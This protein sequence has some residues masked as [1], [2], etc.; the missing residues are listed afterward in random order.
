MSALHDIV[1]I[2]GGPAGLQ[3]GYYLQKTSLKYL[4][5]EKGNDVGEFFQHF[6][7]G[8]DL[9][10]YNKVHTV[11]NDPE[12]ALK[13]DWNSLL[14]EEHS[15]LMRDFSRKLFPTRQ[16]LQEYFT[17]F[18]K[19]HSI[20]TKAGS[21]VVGVKRV[22]LEDL[23]EGTK[24][25][26]E[27]TLADGTQC[28]AA[29]VV[30][31]TGLSKPNIP[32]I[33]GIGHAEGYENLKWDAQEFANQR[34]L[35]L[36]KGNS[37]FELSTLLLDTAAV[38]FMVSPSP[39]K[40]AWKTHH[41]GHVRTNHNSMLDMYQLKTL[42]SLLDAEVQSIRK[43]CDGEGKAIYKVRVAYAHAGGE[44]EELAF[45]R[46][47]RA[48][49]FSCDLSFFDAAIRPNLEPKLGGGNRFP[50]LTPAFE[51]V[52]SPGVFFAGSLTQALDFQTSS[53]P[54][55]HGFRY[56][57]R[58][59]YHM[60][61]HRFWRRTLPTLPVQAST[62]AMA[63]VIL[64]RVSTSSGLFSMFGF[65]ADVMVVKQGI[66]ASDGMSVE[67]YQDL[68]VP[69]IMEKFVTEPSVHVFVVTLEWGKFKDVADT[70]SIQR[71]PT[72]AA[73]AQSKFIHPVIRYFHGSQLVA[74]HHVLED[75]FASF[76]STRDP[77]VVLKRGKEAIEKYHYTQHSM[78][79]VRF[80][81][82]HLSKTNPPAKL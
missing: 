56:N 10:S 2:G 46:I 39:V 59:L 23:Q 27:V 48:T 68:I 67:Y 64:D 70:F 22:H 6:P 53:S 35:I 82:L 76:S 30:V 37:A 45:D 7:R 50:M 8:G 17:S 63:D 38:V 73:A 54:F 52:N 18:A 9:I 44:V 51:S 55:I 16:E 31:A 41:S 69:Y 74:T 4:I 1:V 36:G 40:L 62:D 3:L 75:L 57:V 42:N 32:S 58:S 24:A 26:F 71:F 25:L 12:I 11:F 79:L 20:V 34:V 81:D 47:L 15:P 77:K 49:G 13:W 19:Q 80:L 33:P 66:N 72:A 43:E 21:G 14:S 5:V 65:Q 28:T 78:P 29:N 61:A 60:L